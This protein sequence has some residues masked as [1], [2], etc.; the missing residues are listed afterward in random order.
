MAEEQ[1]SMRAGHEPVKDGPGR[2]SPE[3]A[4]GRSAPHQF[5]VS[6][7]AP[8]NR[9]TG[10]DAAY[11]LLPGREMKRVHATPFAPA[12]ICALVAA[13][14]FVAMGCRREPLDAGSG[15]DGGGLPADAGGGANARG[16]GGGNWASAGSGG[17]G[18]ALAG[19][20][21]GADAT[22][23]GAG[24][25]S[26]SGGDGRGG[27]SGAGGTGGA[28]GNSCLEVRTLDRSCA[29]DDDCFAALHTVNCCG[30]EKYIGLRVTERSRYETLEA[31]CHMTWPACQCASGVTTTDDGSVPAPGTAPSAACR[32]GVCTTY[33]LAC[34]GP[35]APGTTCFTCNDGPGVFA[36]CST[37]CNSAAECPSAELPACRHATSGA[38]YEFCAPS[39]VTCVAP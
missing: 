14:G 22:T 38:Y 25:A 11:N 23:G 2:R 33:V 29:A 16:G 27:G 4:T 10:R 19:A 26:G 7:P 28:S 34:G 20:S 24:G 32:Q 1:S 5:F 30:T 9:E 37:A 17:G 12:A 13:A 3:I 39:G 36:V 35:C 18:G 15:R 31:Q 6:A 8:D 21:G